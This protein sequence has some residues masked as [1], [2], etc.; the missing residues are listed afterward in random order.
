MYRQLILASA[1]ALFCTAASAQ[2]TIDLPIGQAR[3]IMVQSAQGG[4]PALAKEIAEA[5][6]QQNPDDRD[7]LIVLAVAEPRLGNAAAGRAA[8]ARA[9]WQSDSAAQRYEAARLTAL[10]ASNAGEFT[11]ASLWLRV[12][13]IDAPNE[14]ERARTIA[15]G[16]LV[17]QRNPW[18]TQLSFSLAP[19]NNVNGGAE[20]D[21]FSAPGNPTGTLSEDAQALA[22]W[23]ASLGIATQYRIH[24]SESSRTSLAVQG[25]IGR[26]RLTEDT[27][28]PDEAFDTSSARVSLRHDRLLANGSVSGSVSFGRVNFRDLDLATETTEADGYDSR[29]F[30]LDYRVPLSENVSLGLS[31]ARELLLYDA[32]GIGEINR[33]TVGTTVTY[34]LSSGNRLSAALSWTDSD[35]DSVN[36]TSEEQSVRLG[37]T[38]SDPIGPVSLSIG[39]GMRWAEYPDYRILFPVEG[40]RQDET[41]FVDANIGFPN[42]SFAGFTPGLRIDLSQTDSNVGR[43]DRTTATA[44]FTI[45]SQF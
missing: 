2:N 11:R 9:W 6:L 42:V 41:V 13:L 10:A 16:R 36:Y 32:D 33:N 20:D 39:G 15:D 40:G 29:R 21:E 22:G 34:T 12:A 8:G 1:A 14:A 35:G 18:S 23:R 43:F 27:S 24:Q 25:N 37:Y 4:D 28:V 17:N 5:I 3:S 31:Y 26:V 45:A 44:G 30:T 19:S 7:A 38:W